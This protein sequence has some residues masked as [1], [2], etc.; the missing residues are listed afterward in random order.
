MQNAKWKMENGKGNAGNLGAPITGHESRLTHHEGRVARLI[1]RLAEQDPSATLSRGV[2]CLMTIG[3]LVGFGLIL[4]AA[5]LAAGAITATFLA[6]MELGSFI[7][8]GKLVIFGSAV[9]SAVAISIFGRAIESVNVSAWVLAGMVVYGDIGTC[10][11][12]MAN[13][14]VL[15][16]T[17]W[18]GRRLALAHEAGWYVLRANPW[19]RRVA[20]FGV[21]VFVAAPFQGSGAVIGTIIARILGLSRFGTLSAMVVGSATG[22]SALA[23]LGNVGRRQAEDIVSHPWISLIILVAILVALALAGR[24]FVGHSVAAREQYLAEHEEIR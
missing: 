10:L 18:V 23:L 3:P 9:A 24:W 6:A 2:R 5:S 22:C 14:T 16:R 8:G 4:L 11:I 13:M 15:Y 20:W 7:G 17:P 19:M 12:M 1:H 21:A